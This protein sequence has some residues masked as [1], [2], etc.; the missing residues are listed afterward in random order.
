MAKY[1]LPQIIK[2][3]E[4]DGMAALMVAETTTMGKQKGEHDTEFVKRIVSTYFNAVG[5]LGIDPIT[6][7]FI[8]S[9][10]AD[11]PSSGVNPNEAPVSSASVE[12]HRTHAA[13]LAATS[14]IKGTGPAARPEAPADGELVEEI[15]DVL[16]FHIANLGYPV[17]CG[18][19]PHPET[20]IKIA[21]AILSHPTFRQQQEQVRELVEAARAHYCESAGIC[22]EMSEEEFAARWQRVQESEKRICA[23]LARFP[24]PKTNADATGPRDTAAIG[25][26]DSK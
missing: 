7:R 14:L 15:A 25:C 18:I 13:D 10:T 1:P 5:A 4:I 26:G 11:S 19:S 23:I 17:G 22:P 3:I 2:P 9:A 20:L 12:P 16:G 24:S 8:A 6:T 21:R